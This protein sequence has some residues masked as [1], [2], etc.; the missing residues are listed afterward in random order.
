M[1]AGPR[2]FR[3]TTW[4][5]TSSK[6]PSASR[7]PNATG[8]FPT[9]QS[10]KH[11]QH[12]QSRAVLLGRGK[13]CFPQWKWDPDVYI[14]THTYI[15]T[16]MY[17]YLNKLKG[18]RRGRETLRFLKSST[19][20]N[21]FRA[22]V[23]SPLFSSS[24]LRRHGEICERQANERFKQ[25][26]INSD[27]RQQGRGQEWEWVAREKEGQVHAPNSQGSRVG[28]QVES[29]EACEVQDFKIERGHSSDHHSYS[30]SRAFWSRVRLDLSHQQSLAQVWALSNPALGWDLGHRILRPPTC[31]QGWILRGW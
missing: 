5:I 25:S 7:Q 8:K 13:L 26:D 15:Y 16:S 17:I 29:S 24:L 11:M 3:L 21:W 22:L 12:F 20:S 14:Y 19:L 1:S 31:W 2:L 30:S 6:L 18:E 27:T 23:C 28:L 10:Y 4:C 9:L